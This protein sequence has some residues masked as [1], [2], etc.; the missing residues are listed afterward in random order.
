MSY[1]TVRRNIHQMVVKKLI[2]PLSRQMSKSGHYHTVLNHEEYSKLKE[3]LK[4]RGVNETISNVDEM[5]NVLDDGFFYV[6]L[7]VPELSKARIKAGFTSRL[8]TRLSEHL[9]TAPTAELV[10][11]VGC[12]RSWE[13][14]LLA[15]VHSHGTRIKSEVFDIYDLKKMI[16]NLATLFKQMD[17]RKQN[18]ENI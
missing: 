12:M 9:T 3:W 16:K 10:Y 4:S 6:I 7:L 17:L 1:T 13:S 8:E 14:F 5:S 2:G 11:S 18:T 15:Y